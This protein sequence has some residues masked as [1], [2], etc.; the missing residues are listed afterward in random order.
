MKTILAFLLL[1]TVA[2]AQPLKAILVV[3]QTAVSGSDVYIDA[4]QSTGEIQHYLI[5]AEMLDSN[6]R[7]LKKGDIVPTGDKTKPRLRSLVGRW[8]IRLIVVAEDERYD[9][10]EAV[11]LI[12]GIG[13]SCPEPDP[14]PGPQPE[15]QPQPIPPKPVPPG[16]QPLPPPDPIV[17]VGEFGIAPKIYAIGSKVD[18]QT[19]AAEAKQLADACDVFAAQIAAGTMTDP[20]ALLNEMAMKLK[21]FPA[22]KSSVG[23]IGVA[24]QEAIK[25]NPVRFKV[26]GVLSF[27]MADPSAWQVLLK[28]IGVGLRAVK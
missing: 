23:P 16:P 18:S 19:R 22:W 4:S 2:Q 15:P 27:T 25:A 3:P 5:F 14:M 26:N 7:V 17:P 6:G 8:R 11:C 13:G 28:E 21:A 20:Q 12:P 1:A 9:E 10:A 24:I